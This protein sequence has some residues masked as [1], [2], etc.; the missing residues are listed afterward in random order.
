MRCRVK[1]KKMRL[2]MEIVG[3]I[4]IDIFTNDVLLVA[5]FSWLI[6][7]VIKVILNAIITRKFSIERL[8][9]DGGMPSGHS[10]TVTSAAIMCGW[11]YGFSSVYFGIACVLAI[12]VMHDAT[13]VR[14]E[15]GKHAVAINEMVETLNSKA[16]GEEDDIHIAKLKEF[17]G[18]THRQVIVGFI[19]GVIIATVY[20]AIA[21]VPYADGV[22]TISAIFN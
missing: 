10:A 9:G 22:T 1:Q 2:L 6:S 21:G 5:T 18:H 3:K 13:G 20:C 15:A 14:R 7:Q 8:F 17:V 12:I 16:E 4:L 19:L 11:M